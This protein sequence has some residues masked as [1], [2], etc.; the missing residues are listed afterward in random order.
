MSRSLLEQLR[1]EGLQR[2][3][4]RSMKAHTVA[5]PDY[6][7]VAA[8]SQTQPN[9]MRL[10]PAMLFAHKAGNRATVADFSSINR[11]KDV[12]ENDLSVINNNDNNYVTNS[13]LVRP[14]SSWPLQRSN[15]VAQARPLSLIQTRSWT[16]DSACATESDETSNGY[17]N[18]G[19]ANERSTARNNSNSDQDSNSG[20]PDSRSTVYDSRSTVYDSR[21]TVHDSRSN[22]HDSRSTAYTNSN[23]MQKTDNTC[24]SSTHNI[25]RNGVPRQL[26]A[27][28]ILRNRGPARKQTYSLS[29][30]E[31]ISTMF[32]E[33][34][35]SDLIVEEV[36]GDNENSF[37]AT[38]IA[39]LHEEMTANSITV[40]LP[41][42]KDLHHCLAVF[43]LDNAV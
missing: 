34:N 1:H 33:E 2:A 3:M 10:M 20:A 24:Q 8:S 5:S 31:N 38:R 9:F 6:E 39:K 42:C 22:I 26:S 17:Y 19:T 23:M 28:N 4:I 16:F 12:Q 37:N 40:T 35:R 41:Q 21:S 11:T 29:C 18:R 7:N 36:A 25:L 14:N 32:V 15:S 30:Y 27:D 13:K 43:D